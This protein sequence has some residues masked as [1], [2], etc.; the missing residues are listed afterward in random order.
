MLL[1]WSL[2]GGS[3]II[4]LRNKMIKEQYKG[5]IKDKIK[6]KIRGYLLKRVLSRCFYFRIVDNSEWVDGVTVRLST[7][8]G[9]KR[10]SMGCMISEGDFEFGE[11]AVWKLK[12]D[13][14]IRE[15]F[16]T[17]DKERDEIVNELVKLNNK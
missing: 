17:V 13:D 3:Q 15:L 12:L 9:E 10:I 8:I 6:D 16:F 4:Y 5:K 1:I 2:E 7:G 14:T 11:D